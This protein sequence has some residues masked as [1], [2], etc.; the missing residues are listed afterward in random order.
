MITLIE[1][2]DFIESHNS[3][4][5]KISGLLAFKNEGIYL[6]YSCTND[7]TIFDFIDYITWYKFKNKN[8]IYAFNKRGNKIFNNFKLDDRLLMLLLE[9]LNY[10]DDIDI[11]KIRYDNKYCKQFVEKFNAFTSLLILKD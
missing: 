9:K 6:S 7:S 8:N 10:P 5:Y 3:D 4:E 1:G 11:M 2:G